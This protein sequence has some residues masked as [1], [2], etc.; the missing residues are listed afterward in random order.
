[1]KLRDVMFK[2][3]ESFK[4]HDKLDSAVIRPKHTMSTD[5]SRALKNMVEIPWHKNKHDNPLQGLA[6]GLTLQ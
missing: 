6:L 1:M 5:V 2:A 4:Y 3:D